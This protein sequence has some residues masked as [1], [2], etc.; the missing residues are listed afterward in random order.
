MAQSLNNR[1]SLLES[2]VK[3]VINFQENCCG[4]QWMFA[5]PPGVVLGVR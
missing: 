5:L 4:V 3:A 1:A 2:Q